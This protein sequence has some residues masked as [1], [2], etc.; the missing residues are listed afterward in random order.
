MKRQC[1]LLIKPI[2]NANLRLKRE[3][4]LPSYWCIFFN[5]NMFLFLLEVLFLNKK[6]LSTSKKQVLIN[7]KKYINETSLSSLNI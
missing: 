6:N 7:E 1:L 4:Y 2:E 3:V 5:K